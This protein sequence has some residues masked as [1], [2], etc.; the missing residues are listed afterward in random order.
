MEIVRGTGV[1]VSMFV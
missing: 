1:G